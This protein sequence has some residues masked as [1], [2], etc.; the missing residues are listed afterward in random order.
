MLLIADS[1]STKIDWCLIDDKGEKTYFHSIGLNPY[2]VSQQTIDK[3]I[4]TNILP[5]LLRKENIKMFFYGSGCSTSQKKT[6]MQNIFKHYL[7]NSEIHI[8]DDL[9]GAARATC[10]KQRG[11]VAILGTGSN[12][13]LFDGEKI[14]ENIPALGY[15]LCDEGAGTNIGKIVLRNYLRKQMPKHIHQ[16]F[17]QKYPGEEADFLTKLYQGE[18]P[19]FYLASFAQ[20]AI[21]RQQDEY[22]RNI[23]AEAF[24]NFFLMQVTQ[25]ADYKKYPMNVVGSVGYY[26]KNV[27]EEV[28]LHY[29]VTIG[30][31]IKAPLESLITYHLTIKADCNNLL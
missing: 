13:C 2:N 5:H 28:A 14:T 10:G 6:F 16:Q 9:L 11:V 22:C 18:K 15:V 21:T 4:Q 25:Y 23:V 31:V 24:H 26:A 8:E 7:T 30:N 3:E 1:G 12:S 29:G 17:A 27:L 20:F 19:N